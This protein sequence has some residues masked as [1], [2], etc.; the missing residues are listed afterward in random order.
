MKQE[1]NIVNQIQ[2]I[3]PL[4]YTAMVTVGMLFEYHRY[5]IFGINI[6]QY[7]D[8]FDFLI[9]PFK[10]FNIIGA[11]LIITFTLYLGHSLDRFMRKWPKLYH[12][13]NFGMSKKS[14]FNNY[15]RITFILLLFSLLFYASSSLAKDNF[16]KVKLNNNK[17][18]LL[19]ADNDK[20]EGNLIG[21]TKEVIFLFSK[22]KVII[23]PST[24]F[25]KQIE[26]ITKSPNPIKIKKST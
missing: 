24:S 6:F 17:T 7:A 12:I 4:A 14:W 16:N 20:I 26:H 25:I 10:D 11:L 2:S 22:E 13:T 18:H 3:A 15:V 21:K 19:Y 8:I 9:A 5:K 1:K 23:I